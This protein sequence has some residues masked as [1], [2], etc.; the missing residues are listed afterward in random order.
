MTTNGFSTNRTSVNLRIRHSSTKFYTIEVSIGTDYKYVSIDWVQCTV[1]YFIP[2]VLIKNQYQMNSGEVTLKGYG[3]TVN[4]ASQ[5]ID[6]LPLQQH[7]KFENLK[8]FYGI[9]RIECK[10]GLNMALLGV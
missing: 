9:N 5:S 1:I 3:G 2:D 10:D 4:A 8:F 6:L 7:D